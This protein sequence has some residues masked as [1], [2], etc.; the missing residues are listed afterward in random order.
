[1]LSTVAVSGRV[2]PLWALRLSRGGV[3]LGIRVPRSM[4]CQP[5]LPTC[6]GL[7][8]HERPLPFACLRRTRACLWN[9]RQPFRAVSGR[10][11]RAHAR[12]RRRHPGGG[13]RL[14]EPAVHDHRH[15]GARRGRRALDHTGV[16]GGD[17]VPDRR[18][19]VRRGR[20]HRHA[21]LGPRQRAHHRG[22]QDRPQTRAQHRIPVRGDHRHA[23]G[24]LGSSGGRRVLRHSRAR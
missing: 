7:N 24:R 23:G 22:R 18:R 14:S 17:R 8:V 1:M 3:G 4:S 10:R 16:L 6:H 15:R 19:A 2:P 5:Y 11:Q 13:G 12:D 20:V 21:R 9:R